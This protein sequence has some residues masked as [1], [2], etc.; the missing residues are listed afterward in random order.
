MPQHKKKD[1]SNNDNTQ[2]YNV[3]TMKSDLVFII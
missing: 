3:G 1:D 2:Y